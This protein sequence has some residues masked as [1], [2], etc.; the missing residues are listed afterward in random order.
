MQTLTEAGYPE[1]AYLIATQTTFPS[2]GYMIEGGATSTWE[3]WDSD[4][5]GSNMN[6]PAMPILEGNVG[7]WFFQ[8]LAGLALDPAEPAWRRV[9]LRPHPMGTLRSASATRDAMSGRIESSWEVRDGRFTWRLEIPPNV[10]ATA[11]VPTSDP[12]TVTEGGHVIGL[13]AAATVTAWGIAVVGPQRNSLVLTLGSG[14][15]EFAAELR[16][17]AI[18][19]ADRAI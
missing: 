15:Y 13:D 10:V 12:A 5:Q 7:A 11:W 1:I 3:R 18:P 2:W 19:V 16:E 8:A 14:I 4:A 6:S 9:T 17:S